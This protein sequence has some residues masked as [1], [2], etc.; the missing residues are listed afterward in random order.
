MTDDLRKKAL[1]RIR[2][3][4]EEICPTCFTGCLDCFDAGKT[5]IE[6]VA[7]LRAE[8]ERLTRVIAEAVGLRAEIE[9]WVRDTNQ[10]AP[11][12][13]SGL[14]SVDPESFEDLLAILQGE[15]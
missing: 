7:E 2:D 9:Q 6:H 1:R 4:D 3:A 14:V 11:G 12:E 5:H 8:V 15:S 10:N 13:R